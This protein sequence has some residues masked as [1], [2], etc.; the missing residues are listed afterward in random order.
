MSSNSLNPYTQFDPSKSYGFFFR[1]R[2]QSLTNQNNQAFASS[3][4]NKD[5]QLSRAEFRNYLG[6][7][8]QGQLSNIDTVQLNTLVDL[9]ASNKESLSKSDS[10]KFLNYADTQYGNSNGKVSNQELLNVSQQ[11]IPTL[12]LTGNQRYSPTFPVFPIGEG[13]GWSMAGL[14]N[15][16]FQ[17]GGLFAPTAANTTPFLTLPQQ[18]LLPG[19]F[20]IP[21]S[22][23]SFYQPNPNGLTPLGGIN[24]PFT[25]S[26]SNQQLQGIQL[27]AMQPQAA[28]AGMNGFPMNDT[29]SFPFGGIGQGGFSSGMPMFTE[30]RYAEAQASNPYFSDKIMGL[31]DGTK[32]LVQQVQWEKAMQNQGTTGMFN[33]NGSMMATTSSPLATTTFN[34]GNMPVNRLPYQP[35]GVASEPVTVFG[36]NQVIGW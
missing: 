1:E 31:L 6:T 11:F 5:N 28:P 8:S 27:A 2:Q 15:G 9:L 19:Q 35:I 23:Q 14:S 26:L 17:G 32:N 36:Q 3:D 21:L 24:P 18:R 12:Q 30:Q 4:L 16:S 20:G 33:T 13:L 34:M 10:Y 7:L 25:A 22:P 29:Q